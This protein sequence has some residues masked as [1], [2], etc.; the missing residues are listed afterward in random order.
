MS[1]GAGGSSWNGGGH[2]SSEEEDAIIEYMA[3][4][5][6][7][8]E[9]APRRIPVQTSISWMMDTM[10]NRSQCRAMFRLT[11]EE[12]HNLHDLLVTSFGLV[13]TAGV[14]SM[15]KLGIFLY[16]M[17]GNR[18]IRDANNRWVRSNST[19]SVHFHYV[20]QAMNDLAAKILKPVDPNFLD[21]NPQILQENPFK[22]FYQS[23]GAV[24]GTHIPVLPNAASALQHRNRH[25]ITTRNV[26]VICDH[27]GR[28]IFCDAGW[29]GSVHDQ[30]ILNE[31]VQ[32]YPYDFPRV[33]LGELYR[34]I[35]F[36]LL[37]NVLILFNSTHVH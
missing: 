32:A 2:T 23:V 25:H 4:T 7:F 1:Y 33:P 17:G 15:E 29:P 26:L 12:I 13:G 6:D 20:L 27:D 31:A 18:P 11:A 35:H 24:D 3:A 36:F 5:L 21:Y 9:R 30:R 14:C 16:T 19:V 37:P 10:A 8:N 28:I 34:S 22:P